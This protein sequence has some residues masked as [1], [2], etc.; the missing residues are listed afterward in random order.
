MYLP[1]SN[2]AI[3]MRS[4]SNLLMA[5]LKVS[6]KLPHSI[7]PMASVALAPHA[8]WSAASRAKTSPDA[9]E[10]RCEIAFTSTALAAFASFANECTFLP[11]AVRR[12]RIKW[13]K[14]SAESSGFGAHFYERDEKVKLWRLDA[15]DFPIPG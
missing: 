12:F 11:V 1:K 5:S 7:R 15:K 14:S 6:K 9:G 2:C 13:W 10:I 3:P 4:V 8:G